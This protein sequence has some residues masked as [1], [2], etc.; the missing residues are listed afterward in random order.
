MKLCEFVQKYK[1]LTYCTFGLAALGYLGYRSVRKLHHSCAKSKKVTIAAS[2]HLLNKS[3]YW[4]HPLNKN[5]GRQREASRLKKLFKKRWKPNKAADQF[6]FSAPAGYVRWIP[7][8]FGLW[9]PGV[10]AVG[11]NLC[12]K[13]NVH[14]LFVCS[15]LESF[16]D[17]LHQVGQSGADAKYVFI[18]PSSGSGIGKLANN[19]PQHKVSVF[20]E[21]K[22]GQLA[23]ALMDARPVGKNGRMDPANLHQELWVGKYNKLEISMR[24]I[25][26]ACQGLTCP[27]RILYSQVIRERPYGCETFA[28]QD[29][30]IFLQDTTFFQRIVCSKDAIKVDASRE[31]E[32]ITELPADYLVGIQSSSLVDR[33]KQEKPASYFNTPLIGR[34][35]T[36]QQYWDTHIV[37]SEK[38]EMRN[39]YTT[40]KSYK[41]LRQVVDELKSL[42]QEEF[43]EKI[44]D[45]LI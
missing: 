3:P 12:K 5:C 45:I 34:K 2:N 31:I 39:H 23:V 1:T 37:P 38:N 15:T 18:I 20:V 33:L 35:K 26:K 8:D 17:R 41:Y 27:T 10:A 36:L 19:F 7:R 42:S 25:L 28:L 30:M 9:M 6:P 11:A 40:Q 16:V 44:K 4:N 32:A 13:K 24:A 21:K 29:A 22:N 14:G 43:Q